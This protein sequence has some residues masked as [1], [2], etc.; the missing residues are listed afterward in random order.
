M[1]FRITRTSVCYDVKP[2][3]KAV[4][5]K[6]GENE[7]DWLI[8]INTLE[9]LIELVEKEGQIIVSKD[10]SQPEIEIYDGDRE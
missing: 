4:K 1:K 10:N 7:R 5:G 6:I 2:C 9:E 8:E 3:E